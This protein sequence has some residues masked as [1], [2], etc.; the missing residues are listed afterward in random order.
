MEP[1]QEASGVEIA[2]LAVG[3]D[4][5]TVEEAFA[6]PYAV[7]WKNVIVAEYVSHMLNKTWDIVNRPTDK[8]IIVTRFV[9][10]T[11]IN[12]EGKIDRRK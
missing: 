6:D 11:K 4:P 5:T 10:K 8:N 3:P 9:L 1:E 12:R 7:D 2:G